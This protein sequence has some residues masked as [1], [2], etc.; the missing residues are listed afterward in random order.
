M[1]TAADLGDHSKLTALMET[2][3]KVMQFEA[4][5][6]NALHNV[7]AIQIKLEECLRCTSEKLLKKH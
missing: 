7:E 4:R 3:N 6:I 1:S 5:G 2:L